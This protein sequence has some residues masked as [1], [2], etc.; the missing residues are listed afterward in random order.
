MAKHLVVI[1]GGQAALQT[2]QSARQLGHE[3]PITLIA[4]EPHAPYQRP[5]LSKQYLAGKLPRERL[6]L[7]PERFYEEKAIAL[8]LGRSACELDIDKQRIELDD[9]TQ[10]GFDQ[11]VL[12]TGSRARRL[13]VRGAELAGI[14][15]VRSIADIDA[16]RP[17]LSA[18]ARAVIVGGGYIGLEVAAVAVELGVEVTILEAAERLLAR[19]VCA[20]LADFYARYHAEAGVSLHCGAAL[21]AFVG[22]Q[23]VTAVETADGARIPCDLVIVGIGVLPNTELAER[24]GLDTADGILVDTGARTAHPNVF[25]VG[26]CTRHP[27]PHAPGTVRLESVNNAVE[28]GK[29]A[30]ASLLG[31]SAPFESVPWFWSDQY[32]LK[33]QIAGLAL[34]YDEIVVRGAMSRDGFAVYYLADGVPIAVDAVNSPREFMQAKKIVAARAKLSTARIADPAADLTA[35]LQA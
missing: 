28:Q 19:V 8:R 34:G 1:G 11:L 14:H 16:L 4:D 15:Y 33:L 18:G 17:E 13:D 30:A 25:A 3:G 5:P 29:A 23:R 24:A 26:D 31:S 6:Y 7:R 9:G 21:S 20:E 2:V 35:D 27:H 10:L 22:Q 32:D 12:A